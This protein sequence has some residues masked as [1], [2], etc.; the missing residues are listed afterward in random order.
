MNN[1]I[2]TISAVVVFF[3]LYG[4]QPLLPVFAK[5]YGLSIASAGALMTA[6]LIPL[7]IAPLF[8]GYLLST[9]SPIN[10][11]RV[12]LLAMS[13][14]CIAFAVSESYY[15]SFFIRILQGFLIPAALTSITTYIANNSSVA[16]LQRNLSFFITGTILGGLFGRI[17][18]GVFA[19]YWHWQAFYY[20]LA[21]ALLVTALLL[22]KQQKATTTNYARLRI[23]LITQTFSTPGILKIYICVFCLFFSFVAL[24]NFL[25]FMVTDMLG[26]ANEMLLGLM[27]CGFIMGAVTSLNAQRLIYRLGS[28]KRVMTLGYLGFLFAI[29]LLFIENVFIAFAVLFVFCGSMFLV[30]TVATA[31]V[32]Y[33]NKDNKSIVNALYV[34]FYYSGGVS[35]SYFPGMLYQHYG[36]AALLTCLLFVSTFGLLILLSLKPP[37]KPLIS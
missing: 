16:V 34:S 20:S 36:H 29:C 17:M 21:V 11:L 37:S 5:N 9:I 18:A 26:S 3:V 12:A 33:R 24:L 10:L 30:H 1:S 14:S 6:T 7:A 4:V 35:G 28:A 22:P 25:P 15:F 19:A 23:S 8:Y 13:V 32:N 27:Y 31:E 2:S